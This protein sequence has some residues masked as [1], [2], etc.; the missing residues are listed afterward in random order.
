[1]PFRRA[2]WWMILVALSLAGSL[3]MGVYVFFRGPETPLSHYNF[4]GGAIVVEEVLPDS[5]AARAGLQEGDR[6]LS[7]GGLATP[8]VGQ[9]DFTRLNMEAGHSYPLLVERGGKRLELTLKLGQR[10]WRLLRP[11]DRL[12]FLVNLAG[13]LIFLLLA[14]FVAFSRPRDPVARLGALTLGLLGGEFGLAFTGYAALCRRLP[15]L[16]SVF[17]GWPFA[18]FFLLPPLFFSFCA[19]FPRK[20]FRAWW[21]WVLALAPSVVLLSGFASFLG[22]LLFNPQQSAVIVGDSTLVPRIGGSLI[23]SYF[24]AGLLALVLNYRRLDVNEK[25]RVRVLVGGTLISLVGQLPVRALGVMRVPASFGPAHFFYSDGY[26]IVLSVLFLALPLAWAYA[27]LR[28]R[29]FDIRLILRQ[30]LQYALARGVLLIAV[31]AFG[32]LM[33]VDL[34]LHGQQPL[35]EILRARGWVY[36]VLGGLAAMAYVKRRNWLEALDR[37]FFRERYDAQRLLHEV[38]EEVR[39]ARSFD[40]VAPRVVTRIE[41]A[42]H[43][44]FVAL[45]EREVRAPNYRSLAGAPAGQA[46]PLL[47]A[48]SKLMALVRL[49]GKP[50]EVPQTASGWLTEQL[51]HEETEFLR[52][53]RIELLVP[54]ATAAD[55]TEAL[56]VLGSKRSEEPYTR[57]DRDLLVAIASSLALLLEKSSGTATQRSDVFE[58]CPQC[59]SCYDSGA[60]QCAQEGA[61]LVPVVLP[62]LLEGRYRLEKRLG[63]GGMGTVYSASDTLLERRVAVKVIREDLVGS[64]E[65][66][67][68][69]RREAR[70]AA[71]FAHPN[72][73]TVHDFGV[74][75]GTRAFLVMELLEG[76]TLREGLQRQNRFPTAR[77]LPIVRDACAALEAAHRRQLVHRDLKPENIFLVVRESGE[78]T[79]V[80]DFG[81][82]KFLSTNT[83]QV[84]SDTAPGSLVG[85]PRYMS[86]EQWSGGSADAGW[87]LWALA[88]TAYEMLFGAYPFEGR[89]PSEWFAVGRAAKF[90][91]VSKHLSEASPGLQEFFERAFAFD[92]AKRPQSAE[93]FLSELQSAL[94]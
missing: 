15:A 92:L 90:S 72:V 76:R 70:A 62:R 18:G 20:L 48:E 45:L 28:H 14:V 74:A 40:R 23:L 10:S 94:G 73:V 60:T 50:V 79:K 39:E 38:V 42:L 26:F 16:L 30:G 58:E 13:E 52:Q 54:I 77:A 25:R 12:Q 41:T 59:G 43:P 37:R 27:I 65:A 44:E 5:P 33:L 55:H 89:S 47:P 49:L 81:I 46:L 87:D 85:T 1:M 82:A 4:R 7:I 31:P 8:G 6:I 93:T 83:Q 68:R 36:V 19:T 63:R 3:A 69:F 61:R 67:E 91:P 66:A 24:V 56:L 75:A 88:V 9:W 57:E 34:L 86:P 84:T 78:T 32:V 53:A 51:P 71:S 2:P 21:A 80:L 64:A 17:V 22:L 11:I 29:L 35:L